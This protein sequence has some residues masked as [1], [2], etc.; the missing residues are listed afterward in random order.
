M[1]YT[2]VTI[3]G[4]Y[5]QINDLLFDTKKWMVKYLKIDF[6]GILSSK[7]ELVSKEFVREFNHNKNEIILQ[8]TKNAIPGSVNINEESHGLLYFQELKGF[9][10]LGSDGEIGT[11]EDFYVDNSWSI[12]YAIIDI[13]NGLPWSKLIPIETK[14][15]QQINHKAREIITDL[16][17]EILDEAPSYSL[18]ELDDK[19]NEKTLHDF[20]YRHK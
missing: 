12:V 5:G 6:G 8:I 17:V 19:F 20:Y 11:L 10:I 13:P 14:L 3:D 18:S 15:F 7:L 16:N 9:H 4:Y 2:V 1:D